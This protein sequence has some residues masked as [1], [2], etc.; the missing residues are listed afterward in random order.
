MRILI[1]DDNARVRQAVR[2]LLSKEAGLEVC[3]EASGGLHTL[4]RIRELRPNMV[5]LDLNMPDADGFRTARRIRD[6]FPDVKILIVS[7][8]D[9]QRMLPSAIAAGADGCLDKSCLGADLVPAIKRYAG[10]NARGKAG[11]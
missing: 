5:L 1:A 9:P 8:N 7:Q 2:T 4:D 3:G 6:E 11:H 10:Q